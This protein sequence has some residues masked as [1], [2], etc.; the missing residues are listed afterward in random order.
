MK[1]T[2]LVCILTA[3]VSIAQTAQPWNEVAES[4]SRSSKLERP[5]LKVKAPSPPEAL[6]S[7]NRPASKVKLT[8]FTTLGSKHAF[9]IL[10][11]ETSKASQSISLAINEELA[12][13]KLIEIDPVLRNVR[14]VQD[15]VEKALTF[16]RD[17]VTSSIVVAAPAAT[18]S[19]SA[20]QPGS[21]RPVN[22]RKSA[23]TSPRNRSANA[24]GGDSS[25]ALAVGN[26]SNPSRSEFPESQNARDR[27]SPSRNWP[28]RR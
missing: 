12:G 9:F 26:R 17:G 22:P 1:W 18:P 25:N 19:P 16:D 5:H 8:G 24:R 27:R 14:V 4:K 20:V 7:P 21:P 28:P 23:P 15:G 3:R 13:L 6:P 2:L 11:D 10:I